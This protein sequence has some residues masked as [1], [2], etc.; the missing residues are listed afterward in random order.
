MFFVLQAVLDRYL[1]FSNVRKHGLETRGHHKRFS[2]PIAEGAVMNALRAANLFK[3]LVSF[4]LL[5]WKGQ[6]IDVG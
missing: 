3:A 1:L 2:G 6:C 4:K 5:M